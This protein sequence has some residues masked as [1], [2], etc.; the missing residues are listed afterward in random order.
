MTKEPVQG[1]GGPIGDAA[2]GLT[3]RQAPEDDLSGS[4][5][6]QGQDRGPDSL[7]HEAA[8]EPVD[9]FIL[10]KF[11]YYRGPSY[12]LDRQAAV[13][14][15]YLSPDG[16]GVENYLAA[17]T[18]RFPDVAVARPER[19][20][21]LFAA[22]IMEVQRL[23]L[24]LLLHR[25]SVGHDAE[26]YV[27]A[28]EY[29]DLQ[30]AEDAAVLVAD[31]MR[32]IGSGVAFDFDGGYAALKKRFETTIYGGPTAYAL[33]EAGLKRDIPFFYLKAERQVQWG[34]G[35]KQLR[36]RS[37][38]LHIDGI[39][40]TEFTTFKD[41][42]KDFLGQCGFPT[43]GGTTARTEAGA[44]K[45]AHRIGYPVVAKPVAGHK[46]E[47]VFTNLRSD[48]ELLQAFEAIKQSLVGKEGPKGIIIER[49]ITGFDHRLLTVG[50]RF[51]AALERV[52]AYVDGNGVDTI[53]RLIEA[54]NGTEVRRA[55]VRAP[56]TKIIIDDD[57]THFLAGQDL[58][59]ASVPAQGQRVF[60]RRVAN[61]SAGGVSINVTD[62]I[63]PRNVK[64]AEDI[65]GFF[66]VT[67]MG[68]D[69]LAEDISK[70][71]DQSS[72]AI[73]EINA[74]PGVFM[75]LVPAIGSS[76]D[77]PGKILLSH[78]PKAAISARIPIIAGNRISLSFCN[79]LLDAVRQDHPG[80]GFASVTDEGLS[81]NGA[82]LNRHRHHHIN[83]MMA[84]RHPAVDIAVFQH[85][86]HAI[87]DFG[88]FH[89]G[90]DVVV[91]DAA[92]PIEDDTLRRDRLPGGYLLEVLRREVVLWK[93][94]EEMESVRLPGLTTSP[95]TEDVD[96]VLLRLIVPLL[97][98]LLARYT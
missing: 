72:F 53:E 77:V 58:S 62:R 34:Y 44:I 68:I 52:P 84:L 69:V 25:F 29:L 83:V 4:G 43:P 36:G 55:H 91:L 9:D 76:I 28:V 78:F 87:L 89:Q 65:A 82:F 57:L 31:W 64:L 61:I 11:F 12:Y 22:T 7:S 23:E 56:L 37:T 48:E 67:C 79:R 13:F 95:A 17:V 49:F 97:P 51:A 66:K 24:G 46:G 98:D 40:D 32:C 85:D 6:G 60:L 54:E 1:T 27:V 14:N 3:R 26:E 5:P 75:H 70:P 20:I 21:E 81:I 30:T 33:V 8:G 88:T 63:H 2:A 50:G 18:A 38:V 73:I 10:S 96:D 35:R 71:W 47:G 90:A 19:L 42:V 74:G 45:E 59:T 93:D 94:G 92:H 86:K 80:L 39:K 16:P 41:D 15:I